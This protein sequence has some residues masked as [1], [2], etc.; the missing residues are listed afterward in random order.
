[1]VVAIILAAT[2]GLG[3]RRSA[4]QQ[5]PLT[6]GQVDARA[7]AL[8]ARGDTM[9]LAGRL[10]GAESAYYAAAHIAP[11]DGI[12]R[13]AL[14][15][16]YFGR[17]GWRVAAVAMEEAR[18]FGEDASLVAVDIAPVYAMLGIAD[19]LYKRGNDWAALAALPSAAIPLGE[20]LRAEYLHTS[21]PDILGPDSAIVMYTVSDSHL[22]G[23]VKLA[24]GND[25]V[26]AV[27]DARVRGLVLD[28]SWMSRDSVKKFGPKG[29]RDP[30]KVYGVLPR[31]KLGDVTFANVP[32]RFQGFKTGGNALIGLDL[33]GALA[34]TFDPRVGYVLV[35]R[36]G[37]VSDKLSGWR[38]PSFV[39]KY[40]VMVVKGDTMFPV[41]HPD[42]QQYFRAGKWTWDARRG[43]VVVD[44][45]GASPVG[46]ASPPG[47]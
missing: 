22:L 9:L 45:V 13:M 44:S 36:N 21:P 38:I 4:A 3:A 16:Y 12:V 46:V 6:Q 15:R 11:H 23:R 18:H 37:R 1:V 17:G 27:I 19:S 47:Q 42:V 39:G 34:A 20:R 2:A 28:T 35:R 26:F 31:M 29:S 10:F 25:T 30:A 8:V 32:V 33:F 41:G 40:G 24:I 43:T 14:G 7:H 5:P